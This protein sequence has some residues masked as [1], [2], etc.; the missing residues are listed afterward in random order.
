MPT[1]F[2]ARKNR[3]S[4]SVNSYLALVSFL[5]TLFKTKYH[6][7]TG[8]SLLSLAARGQKI[9]VA[10][11]S[12]LILGFHWYRNL[13]IDDYYF[14]LETVE[15]IANHI[16]A[17][18]GAKILAYTRHE[19]VLDINLERETEDATVYIHSSKPGVSQLS[20]PKYEK[21]YVATT[22]FQ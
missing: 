4:A 21:R 10:V 15:T 17:L 3:W 19:S 2:Q 8:K 14:A 22:Y 5:K 1:S 20:G 6:G 12:L 13:G 9:S 18:Y 16:M 11:T 7:F